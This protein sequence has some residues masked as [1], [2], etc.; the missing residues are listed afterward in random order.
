MVMLAG[1][2][3][4]TVMQGQ[5]V[6]DE[7]AGVV[8]KGPLIKAGAV[9]HATLVTREDLKAVKSP[10]TLVC[11]GESACALLDGMETDKVTQRMIPYFPR[12]FWRPAESILG[13]A[14]SSTR[15]THFQTC[16][17]VR[18]YE[19]DALKARSL[20][21]DRLRSIWRLRLTCHQAGSGSSF[22]T[23][24]QMVAGA[25]KLQ[26]RFS[27]QAFPRKACLGTIPRHEKSNKT[28]QLRWKYTAQ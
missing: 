2:H 5:A 20:T 18:I 22:P 21:P 23:N 25:L 8:K 27:I 1:E 3:P 15:S 6:K 16:L 19:V 11:V 28:V 26:D 4:D 14:T 7:E 13:L 17:M 24:A 9:A 12:R 10:L